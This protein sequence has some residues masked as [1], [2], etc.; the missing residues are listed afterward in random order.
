MQIADPLE[1]NGVFISSFI[2][3]RMF[4]ISVNQALSLF[5]KSY[6]KVS[7]SQNNTAEKISNQTLDF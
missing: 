4:C 7:Q 3:I 2:M 5:Y 6:N 1:F